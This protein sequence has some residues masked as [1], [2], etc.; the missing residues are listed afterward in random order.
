M[1]NT[2]GITV[3]IVGVKEAIA[4]LAQF[5]KQV[6][7][8]VTRDAVNKGSG[9]LRDEA[10]RLAPIESKLLKN[11]LTIRTFV[12]KNDSG[13]YCKIGAKRKVKK[14]VA[15]GKDGK[16]K[17]LGG[18]KLAMTRLSQPVMVY[19]SPSR[20]LHLVHFGTKSHLV[21]PKNKKVLARA[22]TIIGTS[23]LVKGAKP[24]PFL[25]TAARTVGKAA[26]NAAI[27]KIKQG[28]DEEARKAAVKGIARAVKKS[29]R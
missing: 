25:D 21:K 10:R 8:R 12:P 20:Y 15:P 6:R 4:G 24:Q 9:I 14:A 3:E 7:Y 5:G 19:R 27:A 13:I 11:N 18:K 28:I 22:G 2:S 17:Q 29:N 26:S 1:A 23:A 16:F